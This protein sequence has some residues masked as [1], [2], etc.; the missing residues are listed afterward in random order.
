MVG[1]GPVGGSVVGG[2]WV[3]G[4]PVG[5]SV[6]DRSLGRWSYCWWLVACGLSVVG[7]FVIRRCNGHLV[8]FLFDAS[9]WNQYKFI[10]F[11]IFWG[12]NFITYCEILII[13]VISNETTTVYA[14]FC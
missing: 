10:A 12:I 1:G 14:K 9:L 4:I 7:G 11:N 6:E 5:G 2:Q 3:G 8:L 13:T